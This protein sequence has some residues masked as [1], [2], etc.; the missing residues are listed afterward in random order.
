MRAYA[1]IARSN[2]TS[3]DRLARVARLS[4]SSALNSESGAN[5]NETLKA[6]YADKLLQ[7]AK[8][9]VI[10]ILCYDDQIDRLCI[11]TWRMF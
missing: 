6:K 5:I 2:S 9:S 8:R 1:S 3:I 10:F 7:K 11:C 4:S